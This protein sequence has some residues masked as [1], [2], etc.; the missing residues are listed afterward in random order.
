MPGQPSTFAL[1]L[2][3]TGVFL[4][5]PWRS[6]DDDVATACAV[7]PQD[8]VLTAGSVV[9]LVAGVV[10]IFCGALLHSSAAPLLVQGRIVCAERRTE[11]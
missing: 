5:Q 7:L 1:G 3:S 6:C 4:L 8:A 9:V 11:E 2:I 10:A